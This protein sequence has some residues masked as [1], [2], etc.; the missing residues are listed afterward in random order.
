MR[1][2]TTTL[3]LALSL[4]GCGS[5]ALSYGDV[6]ESS[7]IDGPAAAQFGELTATPEEIHAARVAA[8]LLPGTPNG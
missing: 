8:G 7:Q 5:A 2:A 4:L 3:A 1:R 6:L